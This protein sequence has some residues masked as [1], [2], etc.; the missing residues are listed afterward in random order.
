[1]TFTEIPLNRG[2]TP[3]YQQLASALAARIEQGALAPGDK[4]PTHRA[5]ADQLGVTVGTVTRAYAEA[6]RR[7]L[8][9]ARVG[10]GTFVR[11]PGRPVWSFEEREGDERTLGY[12]VPPAI[13]R[14]DIMQ[15]AL[16]ELARHRQALNRLM[17]YQSPEGSGQHREALAD[18]LNRHGIAV[19]PREMLFTSGAQHGVQLALQALCRPGDTLLCERLTYP[20]LLSLARQQQ[21]QVRP[22]ELDDEGLVPEALAAACR[23]HQPRLVYLT[24]TLQNPTTATCGERRRQ[25]LLAVCREYGILAL[26]DDVHGLLP[27]ERPAALVNLD[28]GQ[29][30]HVGGLG[31]ALAPGLRLG[32]LQVPGPLR[33][34]VVDGIQNHSWMISPLLTA[35]AMILVNQGA[36]DQLLT[37]VREQMRQRWQRVAAALPGASLR[38]HREGFHGW[39]TLPEHLPLSEFL[40]AARQR[41][42]DLKSAEL[43]T[44]PGHPAPAAVRIA[45]SAPASLDA[46]DAALTLL[47]DILDKPP[48]G[49]AF[50]L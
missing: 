50:T 29:V 13:D 45:A 33:D 8:V 21:L 38:Y 2:D 35:L 11:D 28:P 5:L 43:F 10:A 34:R 48:A 32:Y 31:K 9:E 18:W 47:A 15:A 41:G 24:P 23:Q 16:E 25:D 30:V 4:L 3:L 6:E 27:A 46:L 37:L 17:L 39:L 40:I 26:E 42:L 44:P 12:N 14:S 49:G 20:G 1:M 19:D 22:V 7:G 36:A